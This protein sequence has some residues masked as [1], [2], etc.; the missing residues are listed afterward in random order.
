MN[1][2]LELSE[3]DAKIGQLFMVGIPGTELDIDTEM[4]E[5]RARRIDASIKKRLDI[6]DE[7]EEPLPREDKQLGY[8]S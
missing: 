3:L 5:R 6:Y 2:T 4:L 7:E 1:S 8:I